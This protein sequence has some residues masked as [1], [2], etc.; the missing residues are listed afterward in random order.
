MINKSNTQSIKCDI[1]VDQGQYW[2][3]KDFW[4]PGNRTYTLVID[5]PFN[6]E[7]RYDIK[8]KKGMGLAGLVKQIYR[9]YIRKYSAVE[10][11][12]NDGYWHGIEDLVIEGI[13]VDHKSKIIRLS[14]GS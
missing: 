5:Y 9:C 4:L 8:T 10:R 13:R 2:D 3:G 11:D 14:I 12:D 6:K 1:P 7:A